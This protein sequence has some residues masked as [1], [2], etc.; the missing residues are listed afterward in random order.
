MLLAISTVVEIKT[1]KTVVKTVVVYGSE[2]WPVT[3]KDTKRL[4]TWERK[5]LRWICGPVIGQG[6]WR[7]RPNEEL[8]ELCKDVDVVADVKKN[9]WEWIGHIVVMGHG[10]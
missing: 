7:L 2:T 6:I 10:G 1:C 5:L 8:R 4:N 9:R 3:E